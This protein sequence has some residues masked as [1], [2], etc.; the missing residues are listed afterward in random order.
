MPMYNE[1]ELTGRGYAQQCAILVLKKL[2][3]KYNGC[4]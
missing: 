4:P 3:S 1:E 2:E